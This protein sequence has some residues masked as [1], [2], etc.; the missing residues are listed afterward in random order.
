VATGGTIPLK[1]A[2]ESSM[3]LLLISDVPRRDHP[4]DGV[5]APWCPPAHH[6]L[7]GRFGESSLGDGGG[8]ERAVTAQ[9]RLNVPQLGRIGREPGLHGPPA[10]DAHQATGG[11]EGGESSAVG[12]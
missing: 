10:A 11:V 6:F 9:D 1:A 2:E 8:R 5:V 7:I 12:E 3:T 4:R